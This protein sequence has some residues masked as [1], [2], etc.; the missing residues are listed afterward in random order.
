MPLTAGL[1]YDEIL[2]HRL[3]FDDSMTGD[4]P[5]RIVINYK[6]D[7]EM[8]SNSEKSTDGIESKGRSV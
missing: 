7:D 6:E 3:N 1:Q 5:F 4:T 8:E 2:I